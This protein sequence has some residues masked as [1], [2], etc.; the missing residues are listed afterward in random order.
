M[1][2]V[3]SVWQ[4]ETSIYHVTQY[5]KWA[6]GQ[7][8]KLHEKTDRLPNC[9]QFVQRQIKELSHQGLLNLYKRFICEGKKIKY[10]KINCEI[11]S[12]IGGVS[13]FVSEHGIEIYGTVWS[14]HFLSLLMF[15]S[16]LL[17]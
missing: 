8:K 1:S 9:V 10:F 5:T 16:N 12:M 7:V 15:P 17:Y 13:A 6:V 2:S 14:K 3:M 11:F 4:M